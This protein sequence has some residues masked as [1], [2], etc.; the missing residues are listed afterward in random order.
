MATV[1]LKAYYAATFGGA[2]T[3]LTNVQSITTFSGRQA[4]LDAYNAGTAQIVMRYP[5]GYASPNTTLVPGTQIIIRT[6]WGGGEQPIWYGR[7][8]NV[9]AEYG[10]PYSGGVGNADYL[11]L[12]CEGYFASAGRAPG[13]SYAMA[14]NNVQVQ[15]S[16]AT[17]QSGLNITADTGL[18]AWQMGGTTVS[19]TWGDW[20]NRICLTMNGRML[21]YGNDI[22]VV[23]PYYKGVAFYGNFS[24]AGKS[25]TLHPYQQINFWSLA[26]NYYTQVTVTPESYAAQTTNT[27]SAPYRVYNV[28]TINASA[29]QALD[30]SN[31]LL[32]QYSTRNLKIASI[33]VLINDC[34]QI[35][36]YGA[37]YIGTAI[38]VTFR[39]TV[40]NAI[41]EGCTWSGTPDA[42]YATFYLSSNEMNNYLILNDTVYGTLDYNRLGY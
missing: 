19:T 34:M 11:T 9:T 6:V 29:A 8:Q 21:E 40:Y 27:G 33:R 41:I 17:T 12:D 4:Q 31:F 14:A 7:I 28:N 18:S 38:K 3:A 10:I 22:I 5:T 35:P 24:D 30:Y 2:I 32:N 20:V 42:T 25:E 1:E 13:N 26:D 16:A 23:G 39:G 36:A 15:C 37:S